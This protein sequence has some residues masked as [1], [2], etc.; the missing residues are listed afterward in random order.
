MFLTKSCNAN[1]HIKKRGTVKLGTL[2]HYRNTEI[3][4]IADKGEGQLTFDLQIRT[5]VALDIKWLNTFQPN[6]QL[7]GPECSPIIFPG[8]MECSLKELGIVCAN[9][10]QALVDHADIF[11]RREA[12]NALIFCMS[13]GNTADDCRGIF[14]YDDQ[15]QILQS[16]VRVFANHL[17]K[18]LRV[19][20]DQ[21]D[22]AGLIDRAIPIKEIVIRCEFRPVIYVDRH[23]RIDEST[24]IDLNQ[25][26]QLMETMSFIKPKTYSPER[27][28]RFTFH[29]QHNGQALPIL[30]DHAILNLPDECLAQVL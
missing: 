20:I 10:T 7:G 8:T 3:E 21:P 28:Y 6:V 24:D 19:L 22:R 17:T 29:I 11:I 13:L 27:E 18:A 23:T 2:D 12:P 9:D 30:K 25:L 16:D 1:D 5:P 15:W 26:L 14:D 4:Q